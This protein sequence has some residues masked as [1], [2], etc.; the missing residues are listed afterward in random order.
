MPQFSLLCCFMEW[1][2]RDPKNHL[3]P[4]EEVTM[5]PEAKDMAQPW[6][7][8]ALEVH[9]HGS[10]NFLW[11]RSFPSD[12]ITSMGQIISMDQITFTD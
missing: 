12:Q 9:F 5:A 10:D 6:I 7:Y 11:I 3:V 2:K 1:D 8:M 4:C